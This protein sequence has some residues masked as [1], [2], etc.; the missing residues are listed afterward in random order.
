MREI[1]ARVV[2]L[3]CAM[4]VVAAHAQQG[5]PR[6]ERRSNARTPRDPGAGDRAS[7][8]LAAASSAE[9][10]EEDASLLSARSQPAAE[11]AD[12]TRLLEQFLKSDEE[13]LE[14]VFYRCK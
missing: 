5:G 10:R 12:Y 8:P 9:Q 3:L 13:Q 2:G 14:V 1:R 6:E 4:I 7:A 11:S